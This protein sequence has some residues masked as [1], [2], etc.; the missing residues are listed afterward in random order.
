MT[1]SSYRDTMNGCITIYN[2]YAPVSF[3]CLARFKA[4]VIR[5]YV[6]VWIMSLPVIM[7]LLHTHD[8]KYYAMWATRVCPCQLRILILSPGRNRSWPCFVPC[9]TFPL[10]E[11]TPRFMFFFRARLDRA[12][13]HGVISKREWRR[14]DLSNDIIAN[15][16]FRWLC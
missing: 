10:G 16:L 6:P 14:R 4:R 12:V 15:I 5:P 9:V 2:I 3:L 1:I 8:S 11:R 7:L 13:L